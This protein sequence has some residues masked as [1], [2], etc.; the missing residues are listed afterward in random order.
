MNLSVFEMTERCDVHVLFVGGEDHFYFTTDRQSSKMFVAKIPGKYIVE[1]SCT[2]LYPNCTS[3]V[4]QDL[5]IQTFQSLLESSV[6]TS[7]DNNDT[8]FVTN[9]SKRLQKLYPQKKIYIQPDDNIIV[10]K[11]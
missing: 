4:L 1:Y 11:N 7:C 8:F 10:T 6:K 2:N 5:S 9:F 3:I